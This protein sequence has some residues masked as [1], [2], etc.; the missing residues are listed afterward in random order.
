MQ[1]SF[2]TKEKNQLHRRHC[3]PSQIERVESEVAVILWIVVDL[4][5]EILDAA[6]VEEEVAV[7]VET[8][9]RH[10]A[11]VQATVAHMLQHYK[12]YYITNWNV[13]IQ[14]G[15]T[16]RGNLLLTSNWELHLSIRSVTEL[17]I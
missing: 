12:Y 11:E 15:S 13:H 3:P 8:A 6:E 1:I 16:G 5:G 17:R 4:Y 10:E 7:D 14:G 9:G 2:T